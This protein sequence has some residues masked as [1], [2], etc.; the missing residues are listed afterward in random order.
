MTSD[1][2]LTPHSPCFF[3]YS[4]FIKNT[5]NPPLPILPPPFQGNGREGPVPG[6]GK[7]VEWA[8]VV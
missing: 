2:M 5:D 7:T 6:L 1:R 3:C 8:L 4:S